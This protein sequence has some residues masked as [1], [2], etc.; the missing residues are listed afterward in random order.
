[1]TNNR[2][3]PDMARR[4]VAMG[5]GHGEVF[6]LTILPSKSGFQALEWLEFRRLLLTDQFV[7]M[8][9]PLASTWR[10]KP[11]AVISSTAAR[12]PGEDLGNKSS[13]TPCFSCFFC[14]FMFSLFFIL[15]NAFRNA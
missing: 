3:V 6:P 13:L 11:I 4:E 9:R 15:A 10:L 14:F 7:A 5:S 1:M 8:V 12:I 2:A